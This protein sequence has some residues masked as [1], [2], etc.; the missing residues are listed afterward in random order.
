MATTS[1]VIPRVFGGTL[2]LGPFP[3]TTPITAQGRDGR[4]NAM[5]RDGK[6]AATG[7]D[8]RVPGKGR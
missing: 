2:I 7:R 4:V 5:G 1:L 3:A 8:G 6:Q